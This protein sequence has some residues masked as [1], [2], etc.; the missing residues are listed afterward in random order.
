MWPTLNA[1]LPILGSFAAAQFLSWGLRDKTGISG[2]LF[3]ASGT[4]LLVAVG[5][6][7]AG[8][9]VEYRR[10]VTADRAKRGLLVKLRDEYMKWASTTAEMARQVHERRS[11]YLA[12]V[13]DSAAT[14][15]RS[16]VAD[17]V[18]RPR[19]VV[20]L[21]N[22]D[23]QPYRMEPI[24]RSGRGEKPKPFIAGTPRGD[25]ALEFIEKRTTAHYS[26]LDNR[27]NP[28]PDGYDGTMA[29]YKTFVAAPIWTETGVYGMVTLDAPRAKSF[30][31]GD[32]A[33]VELTA[34]MMA[35]AFE[36]G[37]DDNAPD[38]KEMS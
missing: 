34:E 36:I 32:V 9:I 22:P 18:S 30:D 14:S 38:P 33:L 11:A 20:Y 37:Q 13:A 2:W 6:T 26:D 12:Q 35:I 21:L 17:H 15:L 16:V 25:A 29:G 4:C 8:K 19:A 31:D 3:L 27:K 1:A 5:I 24:G 23:D 28:R 7:I 10:G